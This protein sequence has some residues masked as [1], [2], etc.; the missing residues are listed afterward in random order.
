M[1]LTILQIIFIWYFVRLLQEQ[2]SA[3]TSC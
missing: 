1:L 3:L 2:Y